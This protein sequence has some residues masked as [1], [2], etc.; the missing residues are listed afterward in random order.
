MKTTVI[1]AGKTGRGFLGCLLL[2]NE[3]TFI[4][5]DEALVKALNEQNKGHGTD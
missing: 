1:G 2:G 5:K 3:V 4:D